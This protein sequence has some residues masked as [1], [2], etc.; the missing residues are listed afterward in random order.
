MEVFL[1]EVKNTSSTIKKLELQEA[2]FVQ[3]KHL[4]ESPPD[5]ADKVRRKILMLFLRA[6][7]M[8]PNSFYQVAHSQH[9]VVG[10]SIV[11]SDS[12]PQWPPVKVDIH[13]LCEWERLTL[14]F[15]YYKGDQ[16]KR[17]ATIETTVQD[18]ILATKA[19]QAQREVNWNDKQASYVLGEMNVFVFDVAVSDI[20]AAFLTPKPRNDSQRTSRTRESARTP[21]IKTSVPV[22][23]SLSFSPAG[24]IYCCYHLGAATVLNK[25]VDTSLTTIT[26]VSAG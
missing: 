1:C 25:I 6:T 9:K 11:L 7:G 13:D 5:D 4:F 21:L 23:T 18:L 17:Y 12:N 10:Q 26:G 22:P 8:P 16:R 3:P 15:Y 20:E 2:V 14:F 24:V 19:Y